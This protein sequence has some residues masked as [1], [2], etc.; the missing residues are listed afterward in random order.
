[1]SKYLKISLVLILVMLAGCKT[2][3]KSNKTVVTKSEAVEQRWGD[4]I[5]ASV[6]VNGNVT[7]VEENGQS[8]TDDKTTKQ[9]AANNDRQQNNSTNAAINNE[10]T[11]AENVP[12]KQ[13]QMITVSIAIDCKTIL[14]NMDKVAEPYK[15][16]VP[17]NGQILLNT[18]YQVKK[19]TTVLELLRQVGKENGINIVANGGYVSSIKN[20][21]QFCAGEKSGWMYSV[22]GNYVNVG[23]GGKKLNDGDVVKWMF[24]CDYGKDLSW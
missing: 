20:L 11:P 3:T 9:T 5:T 4:E 17:H 2:T 23:A 21:A 8:K 10:S 24:T 6:D 12:D 18:T 22:N 1:M 14:N 7:V 13:E 15:S 16:F 19:N